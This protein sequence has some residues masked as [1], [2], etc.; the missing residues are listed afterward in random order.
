MANAE[1]QP[2]LSLKLSQVRRYIV[3]LFIHYSCMKDTAMATFMRC[4]GYLCYEAAKAAACVS[5]SPIHA[6]VPRAGEVVGEG[7]VVKK[8]VHY[9]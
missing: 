5:Q 7:R 6:L 2:G 3:T 1:F 4:N 8:G 9:G